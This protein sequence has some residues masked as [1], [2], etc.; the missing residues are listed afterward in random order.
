[1]KYCVLIFFVLLSYF[2]CFAQKA[3]RFEVAA[4]NQ[5]S[6]SHLDSI[7]K[8]AIHTNTDL[9]TFK[10]ED[11]QKQ[12]IE[13]YQNLLGKLAKYLQERNFKWGKTVRCFN[14]IYFDKNGTI[15]YF[16]YSFPKDEITAEQEKQFNQLLNSFILAQKID[17][18]ANEKF[19]QC[20]P[21]QY[22]DL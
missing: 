17:I 12:L 2:P 1:M 4:E 10:S 21:V 9:A 14:R 11:Q 13:A 7:Y 22:T 6:A 8:S 15:D 18:K 3:M 16:L 5:K 20:S 19:A